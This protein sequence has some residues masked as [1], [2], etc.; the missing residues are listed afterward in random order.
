M[1][2]FARARLT[3]AN[4]IATTALALGITGLAIVANYMVGG[5]AAVTSGS[6]TWFLTGT[7]TE[8]PS[9]TSC[10]VSLPA[11]GSGSFG[12]TQIRAMISSLLV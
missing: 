4:V 2:E 9:C 1:L 7:G 10:E 6:A 8:L 11:S 5:S 3:Y 12:S